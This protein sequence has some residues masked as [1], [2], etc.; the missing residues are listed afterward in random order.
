MDTPPHR[1]T[2]RCASRAG[3]PCPR[4]PRWLD[5]WVMLGIHVSGHIH[6][7]ELMKRERRLRERFSGRLRLGK[8]V[9]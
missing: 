7:D 1:F 6:A 8:E 3:I 9:S 5:S 4:C 2:P